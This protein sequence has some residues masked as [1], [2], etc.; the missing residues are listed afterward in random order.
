[1]NYKISLQ[2]LLSLSDY[3]FSIY[4]VK[5]HIFI[6]CFKKVILINAYDF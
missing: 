2:N 5:R 4:N 3:M 1:M 6:T